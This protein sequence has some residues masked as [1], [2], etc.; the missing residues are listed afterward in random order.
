MEARRDSLLG[1]GE[2][3]GIGQELIREAQDVAAHGHLHQHAALELRRTGSHAS[4]HLDVS[5]RSVTPQ[6][7]P[8]L[9]HVA[10]PGY[11]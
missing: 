7:E 3:P 1:T 5:V 6:R 11:W 9:V 8:A 2:E 4:E 10:T